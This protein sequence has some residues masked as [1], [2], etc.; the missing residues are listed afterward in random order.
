MEQRSLVLREMVRFLN[1]F[2]SF[3]YE[4]ISWCIDIAYEE[5]EEPP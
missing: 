2:G 3:K 5:I 1:E 4:G